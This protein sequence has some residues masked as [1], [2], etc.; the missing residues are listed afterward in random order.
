[1]R[2]SYGG[3]Q[4]RNSFLSTRG[5]QSSRHF[6]GTFGNYPLLF[7]FLSISGKLGA[8]SVWSLWGRLTPLRL[9]YFVSFVDSFI[10]SKALFSNFCG[11]KTHIIKISFRV[12]KIFCE[13]YFSHVLFVLWVMERSSLVGRKNIGSSLSFFSTNTNLFNARNFSKS[14]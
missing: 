4:I 8:S 6:V 5:P 3:H 11:R 9:P 1:M 2:Q 10:F 12:H 14:F 13:S 7:S